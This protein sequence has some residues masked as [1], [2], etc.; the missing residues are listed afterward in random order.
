MRTLL[1]TLCCL[2]L[3]ACD[4]PTAPDELGERLGAW[5]PGP[6][7]LLSE[8]Y[9]VGGPTGNFVVRKEASWDSCWKRFGPQDE[10]PP[11]VDFENEMVFGLIPWWDSALLDSI[12]EFELGA[13]MYATSDLWFPSGLAATEPARAVRMYAIPRM[14]IVEIRVAPNPNW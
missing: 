10:L 13:R 11:A 2:T 8:R 3:A 5:V 9:F 4:S 7:A 12:V 6:Q 1:F 14:E